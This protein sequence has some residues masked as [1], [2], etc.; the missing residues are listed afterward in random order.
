MTTSFSGTV[1]TG[2]APRPEAPI[3]GTDGVLVLDTA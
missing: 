3:A 2:R 1:E